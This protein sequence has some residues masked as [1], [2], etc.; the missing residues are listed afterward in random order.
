VRLLGSEDTSDL[1]SITRLHFVDEV[2]FKD[3]LDGA[4]ELTGWG[5]LGHLLNGNDLRVLVNAVAILSR[6]GV[7]VLVLCRKSIGLLPE[8]ASALGQLI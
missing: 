6:E 5:S 8:S 7:I 4:R 3:D 2:I 1:H